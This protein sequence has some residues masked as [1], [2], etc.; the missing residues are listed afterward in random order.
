VLVR[1]LQAYLAQS[2][3]AVRSAPGTPASAPR[4]VLDP[5]AHTLSWGF[6]TQGDYDQ[7]G[8]VNVAD[9][10]PL[11]VHFG[12]ST[13]GGP[14]PLDSVEAA[15]DGDG[16]GEINIADL[17]PIGANFG[18]KTSQY[19][20]YSSTSFAD[21]P[22]TPTAANGAGAV[23]VGS[24]AHSAATGVANQGRLQYSYSVAAFAPGTFYWIRPSDGTADGV[25]SNA[26]SAG[27][28]GNQPP[29]AVLNA[30]PPSGDVPLTVNFDASGSSDP[31]GATH[32]IA[33]IV[34]FQWDFDG[35]GS[36]D[37]TTATPQV[38]HVYQTPG[39]YPVRLQVTDAGG[40]Q[41]V[42]LLPPLQATSGGNLPPVPALSADKT[43]GHAAMEVLFD[44]TGTTDDAG[45]AGLDYKWDFDGDGTD[46]ADTANVP[47]ASHTYQA[48][49]TYNARLRVKDAGGLTAQRTVQITVA[50][51]L[52]NLPPVASFSASPSSGL[53]PLTVSFDFSGSSD[54]DGH[55]VK[56]EFDY[57]GDGTYDISSSTLPASVQFQYATAGIRYPRL[58][59]TD[60]EG[61]TSTYEL[62]IRPTTAAGAGFSLQHTTTPSSGNVPLDVTFDCTGSV[63]TVS[64]IADYGFD[65]DGDGHIDAHGTNPVA[66]YTYTNAGTY[67]PVVWLADSNGGGGIGAPLGPVTVTDP[68]NQPPTAHLTVVP[69]AAAYPQTYTLDASGSSDADGSIAKY[70]WD[71]D[72]DGV[73]DYDSGPLSYVTHRF[74]QV[75]NFTPRVRVT[76]NDGATDTANA[77]QVAVTSGWRSVSFSY[78]MAPGF[79]SPAIETYNSG[80]L[81][82]RLF[83]AFGDTS[84]SYIPL[85]V[86]SDEDDFSHWGYGLNVGSEQCAGAVSFMPFTAQPELFYQRAGANGVGGISAVSATNVDGST[87]SAPLNLD[88]TG[89]N[90]AVVLS[91][92]NIDG[93]PGL[94]ATGSTQIRF[95]RA[96][97]AFGTSW[98]PLSLAATTPV[99]PIS[100]IG[101]TALASGNPAVAFGTNT[102]GSPYE[103]ENYF[104]FSQDADGGSWWTPVVQVEGPDTSFAYGD[105]LL[106][107]ANVDGNPAMVYDGP[108]GELLYSRATSS[109]G[110]SW[111][112]PRVIDTVPSYSGTHSYISLLIVD[113][114]PLVVCQRNGTDVVAIQADDADGI[115]WGPVDY[116]D[117]A[118][119]VGQ[120]CGA[121]TDG[122]TVAIA[123]F[124]TTNNRQ[125]VSWR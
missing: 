25:A 55:I 96:A 17:Q 60:D 83:A 59:V 36:F 101:L 29:L 64:P 66:H 103:S 39:V 114:R 108:A 68:S 72:G 118:G 52:T 14:F 8:E 31:D 65:F 13:G 50:S 70:E 124:D 81:H 58:R 115:S 53:A 123:Y 69:G 102:I 87:W 5:A 116:V 51:F 125:K 9:L 45:T 15:V 95:A 105:H 40:A 76:D 109:Y 117:S 54:P 111:G 107:C 75:G 113:G 22:A 28:G 44:A 24:V 90:G 37:L 112:A 110:L 82:H 4:L 104:D 6:N 38:S 26:V 97:D 77:P 84:G 20:I 88:S 122:S 23:L 41:G 12:A 67:Q 89:Q 78:V 63:G 57:Q 99:Y 21:Y 34:Q 35:D 85:V 16:N 1:H 94:A 119:D 43:Y 33:D 48:A 11:G 49:G 61:A 62:P 93:R 79:A 30:V 32:T 7:N 86:C 92:A 100:G 74:V 73:F 10:Q 3:K 98:P 27:A 120:G 121:V 19:N 56:Y 2:G 106:G 47:A 18:N 80:E 71:W 91:S 42:T 46:D